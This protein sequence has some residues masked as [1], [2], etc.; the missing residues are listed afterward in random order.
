M[1]I[2]V[3]FIFLHHTI[4]SNNMVAVETSEMGTPQVSLSVGSW[5]FVQKCQKSTAS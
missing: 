2:Q 5:N 1:H 4:N 3:F